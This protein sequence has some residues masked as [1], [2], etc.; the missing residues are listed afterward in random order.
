MAGENPT[1]VISRISTVILPLAA[2]LT[3]LLA[4]PSIAARVALAVSG[5]PLLIL[6]TNVLTRYRR[7]PLVLAAT[8][9]IIV[10][11]LVLAYL[12]AS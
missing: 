4:P 11:L 12:R 10:E 7:D 8:A 9:A 2:L 1:I 5:L 3:G 6:V